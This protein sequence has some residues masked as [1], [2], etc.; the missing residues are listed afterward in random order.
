VEDKLYQTYFGA[1]NNIKNSGGWMKFLGILTYIGAFFMLFLGLFVFIGTAAI[2]NVIDKTPALAAFAFA[3]AVLGVVFILA[4]IVFG[5]L[6]Y[7]MH[8]SG[9]GAKNIG[10]MQVETPL[11]QYAS[12]FKKYLVFSFVLSLLSLAGSLITLIALL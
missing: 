3:P 5:L 12:N 4:A 10:P 2:M 7:W 6:A 9:S 8:A 11:I 1:L